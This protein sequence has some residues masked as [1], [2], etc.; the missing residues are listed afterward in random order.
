MKHTFSSLSIKNFRLFFIGQGISMCGTWMQT[1]AQTWL[2]L[3]LTNSG[4]LLGLVIAL[5]FLPILLF[6]PWGG[7]IADRFSKKHILYCTQSAAGILALIMGILVGTNVIQLWMICVL[8]AA[9][10]F[11]TAIDNPT[12]QTFVFEMVG[13]KALKNA[14]TLNS[15]EINLTR[16]IGP[17]V[18]GVLIATIGIAQCFY[19]NAVSYIAVLI[20]L[21]LMNTKDLYASQRVKKA[22]GQVLEGLKYVKSQPLLLHTLLMM[23]IIGTLSY[24]FTVI[25]PLVARFTFN[26]NAGTYAL[27]T[28]T[29]AV[30]SVVGGLFF[31]GRQKHASLQALIATALLFGISLIIAAVMPTIA[32]EVVVL[33][34]VGVFSINFIS[35]GNSILQLQ[36]DPKMRGRV[37]ALWAV[38]FLGSTPVGGPII[39]WIGEHASPRW[40]LI[41]GGVAAVFAAVYGQMMINRLKK[42]FISQKI[43]S[44]SAESLRAT[45]TRL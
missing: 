20:V 26:G 27:F 42:N 38:A 22:K 32:T 6:G 8:A 14:V 37:M 29:S 4:T 28:A 1:V 15:T 30:G 23:A 36:S 7:V 13:E 31:A 2:V 9:L 39:G 3:K 16:V 43:E 44:Q 33:F 18:A 17:S 40:G 34:F 25:L 11:V 35:L 45:N 5:Q 10:G 24:E 21:Y 41:V 12:R 19:F